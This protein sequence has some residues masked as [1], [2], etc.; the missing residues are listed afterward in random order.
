MKATH[1]TPAEFE[2]AIER[3]QHFSGN[4]ISLARLILVDQQQP[5]DAA[6]AVGYTRQNAHQQMKRVYAVLNDYPEDWVKYEGDFMPSEMAKEVRKMVA[7]AKEELSSK[8]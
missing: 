3:L 7:S 2:A 6:K 5:V 4:T 1:M 8:K